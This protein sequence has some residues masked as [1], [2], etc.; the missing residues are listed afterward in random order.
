[1]ILYYCLYISCQVIVCYLENVV[2]ILYMLYDWMCVLIWISYW[3]TRCRVLSSLQVPEF[4]GGANEKQLEII[5]LKSTRGRVC[6]RAPFPAWALH[7]NQYLW[8][9]PFSGMISKIVLTL[10]SFRNVL[11]KPSVQLSNQPEYSMP[12]PTCGF[13]ID[14]LTAAPLPSSHLPPALHA[15]SLDQF[16]LKILYLP[17]NIF[18]SSPFY[19][20][21]HHFTHRLISSE[22]LTVL[23]HPQVFQV[24]VACI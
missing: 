6:R 3:K 24:P 20:E 12:V 13:L 2:R 17:L 7:A 23:L 19:K 10:W 15:T 8:R 11:P 5:S 9:Q 18:T 16:L 1:M 14:F 22:R 21:L 4:H